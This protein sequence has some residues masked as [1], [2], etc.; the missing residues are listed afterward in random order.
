MSY[1]QINK[2]NNRGILHGYRSGL[3]AT[4]VKDLQKANIPYLYEAVKL[5]YTKPQ[6]SSWLRSL[7]SLCL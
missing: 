4:I 7:G 1:T 2:T 3:E 6:I 5:S